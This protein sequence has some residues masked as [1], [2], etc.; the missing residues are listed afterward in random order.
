MS[1]LESNELLLGYLSEKDENLAS[2]LVEKLIVTIKPL[3]GKIV[4]ANLRNLLGSPSHFSQLQDLPDVCQEVIIRLLTYFSTAREKAEPSNI[5]DLNAYVATVSYNCCYEYK[6]RKYPQRFRLKKKLQY[7]FTHHPA[8]GIWQDEA[9]EWFGGLREWGG[10]LKHWKIQTPQRTQQLLNDRLPLGVQHV[11]DPTLKRNSAAEQLVELF[12]WSQEFIQLGDLITIFQ[13]WWNLSDETVQ[14][15]EYL[16]NQ[17]FEVLKIETA[18]ENNKKLK[19]VWSEIT[20]LPLAQRKALLLN[21]RDSVDRELVTLLP[22]LKIAGLREIATTLE[23]T[24]EKL[25]EVWNSLPLNDQ[26][27]AT[28]MGLERRQVI[29]LRRTARERLARRLSP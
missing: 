20:L 16:L 6:Q 17:P 21:L 11:P 4:A 8:L 15:E 24:E 10:D 27:I 13:K 9:Q 2:N 7:L 18:L 5:K 23:I 19:A 28:E 14:L 3:I 22:A 12:N 26:Q 25:G 29:N 1:L